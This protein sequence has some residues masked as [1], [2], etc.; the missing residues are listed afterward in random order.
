[1]I[2]T[3][4]EFIL[5]YVY[6]N[7]SS[8]EE[9]MKGLNNTHIDAKL[10]TVRF[11]IDLFNNSKQLQ[12]ESKQ[13]FFLQLVR[14]ELLAMLID[15]ML[16]K[17]VPTFVPIIRSDPKQTVEETVKATVRSIVDRAIKLATEERKGSEK[18]ERARLKIE[19]DELIHE[20]YEIKKLELLKVHVAEILTGC[21]QILPSKVIYLDIIS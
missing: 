2:N 17:E 12:I 1:M 9:I 15:I 18:A 8:L 4:Y 19:G 21:L 16:Y 14:P 6:E 5:K 13:A 3:N 7:E 10:N 20:D 11:I